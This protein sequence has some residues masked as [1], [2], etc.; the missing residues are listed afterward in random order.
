MRHSNQRDVIYQVVKDSYDHPTAETIML[1]ARAIIPTINIATTYRNLNYLVS[2]N[3]VQRI[4]VADGDRFDHTLYPH[5]H[6]HCTECY[7]VSDI[8]IIDLNQVITDFA[9]D[10]NIRISNVD[11]LIEGLCPNC[12]QNN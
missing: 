11:L 7:G 12:N 4:F 9:K 6:F 1:R 2:N 3:M 8:E 10:Q 5:A